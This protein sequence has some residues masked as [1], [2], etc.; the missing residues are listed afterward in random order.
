MKKIMNK[1]QL[2]IVFMG[3]PDFAV[4]SLKML[5]QNGYNVAAVV[6]NLDKPKGRG[7]KMLPPPA[8]VFAEQNGI[9]VLQYGRVSREGL[10]DIKKIAPNLII[11]AAFGQILSRELLA[12]PE[13][14]CI[15]VHGSL[16]PKYR[17]A[18]P[19]QWAIINGEKK[20]G[21]TTMYTVYELDA[22]DMLLKK[23][24]DIPEDITGGELFDK[25][26]YLGA[27]CLEETLEKLLDG[28]L[29][30]TPQN[31]AEMTYYP[32]FE[33][34]FGKIDFSKTE[35]Q[36]CNFI[37]G[38]NPEP[39]AYAMLG[40]NK[41]KVFKAHKAE[42][43]A[44]HGRIIAANPKDGLIVAV[45]DGAVSLDEIQ[46]AG[47]KRMCAKDYLRGRKIDAGVIL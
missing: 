28:T 16:L 24:M 34:G 2:K 47:S 13:Y 44:E 30:A 26:S 36:V 7:H 12:V 14:G 43:K 37:R 6:T 38:I 35:E 25:L 20:T 8:K 33:K 3:T 41:L 4:P 11:T 40:E 32:M 42:G 5:K 29:Q 10:E 23:E 46:C 39:G 22:G 1:E 19:V 45:G 18:A 31:D 21:I 15:N 27:E 17:G 9:P